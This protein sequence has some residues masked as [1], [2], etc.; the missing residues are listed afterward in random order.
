MRSARFDIASHAHQME[1]SNNQYANSS[2]RMM[3][4]LF[5]SR[6]Q[7]RVFTMCAMIIMMVMLLSMTKHGQIDIVVG[8]PIITRRFVLFISH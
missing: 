3:A 8:S 4:L 2:P 7:S 1:R 5:S 6:H